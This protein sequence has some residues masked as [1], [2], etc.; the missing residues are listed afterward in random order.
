MDPLE[1]LINYITR[2]TVLFAAVQA[3]VI[4]PALVSIIYEFNSSKKRKIIPG[5]TLPSTES[6]TP[7]PSIRLQ[8]VL[9]PATLI[10][11]A[12]VCFANDEIAG[13]RIFWLAL[14]FGLVTW[15]LL[16]SRW[17]SERFV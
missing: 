10:F 15:L 13:H 5:E 6:K 7:D 1:N 16:F 14:D 9:Y 17:V 8:K 4:I 2:D 12:A 3:M 11:F